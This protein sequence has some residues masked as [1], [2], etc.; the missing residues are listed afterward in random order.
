QPEAAPGGFRAVAAVEPL[1]ELGAVL[2]ADPR[3]GVDDAELRAAVHAPHRHLDRGPWGC[4]DKCVLEQD[5]SD[6]EDTL[7]I[8]PRLGR[9]IPSEVKR[10]VG[11]ASDAGEL[12]DCRPGDAA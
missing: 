9:A 8:A 7:R 3:A 11:R 5:A 2:G 4:V 6:L 1:E 10:V 12:L